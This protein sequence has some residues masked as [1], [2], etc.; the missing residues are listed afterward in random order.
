MIWI[1]WS[2][3]LCLL[4]YALA[5]GGWIRARPRPPG[6]RVR[7]AWTAAC[8][9][10]VFHVVC[11]F[12]LEHDWSHERAES[13]TR[14]DTL[15]TL[16]VDW[17]GGVWINY[18]LLVVWSADAAWWWISPRRYHRRPRLL[19]ISVHAFIAFVALSGAVLFETGL[20]RYVAITTAITLIVLRTGYRENAG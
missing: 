3:R 14:R 15:E 13:A 7:C 10:L 18:L 1:T 17:G 12:H 6:V 20:I 4:A 11:A 9:L 2:I 19:G 16:G 5:L 8:A